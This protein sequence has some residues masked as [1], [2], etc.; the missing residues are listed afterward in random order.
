MSN[1]Y[2]ALVIGMTMSIPPEVFYLPMAAQNLAAGNCCVVIAGVVTLATTSNRAGNAPFV[3]IESIDNSGGS[4]GSKTI[5][6]VGPRQR[7]T[8]LTV[9]NLET[10]DYVKIS[11]TDG[12]VTKFIAGT[13]DADLIYGRYLSEEGAVFSRS[14]TTPYTETLSGGQKPLLNALAGDV[15]IIELE[16]LG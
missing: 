2:Q 8:V 9:S 11:S 4:S 7:V 3:P 5:G 1:P 15:V 12:Q 6:G 14:A 10:N 13:D 16:D